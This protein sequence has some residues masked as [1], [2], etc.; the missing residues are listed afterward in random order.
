MSELRFLRTY[1]P[2]FG[3]ARVENSGVSVGVRETRHIVGDYTYTGHD[4]LEERD[5]PDIAAYVVPQYLGVPYRCLLPRGVDNLL[6]ASK[7]ISVAPGQTSSG[8][9]LGAYNDMK[10][11]PTVMTYGEAAGVAAAL[12]T[13]LEATPRELDIR[14]LQTALRNQGALLAPAEIMRLTESIKLPDGTPYSRFLKERHANL[15]RRWEERGVHF[16]DRG[17]GVEQ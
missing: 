11:I 13:K 5:F 8:P 2:G 6:L 15:R 17:T 14:A 1:I 12:C 9:A 3:T 4:V 16:Y 7:C 10:S